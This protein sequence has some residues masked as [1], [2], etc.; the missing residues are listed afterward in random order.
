MW[1][2]FLLLIISRNCNEVFVKPRESEKNGDFNY[3]ISSRIHLLA[4]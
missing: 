1:T 2:C 4:L 3:V